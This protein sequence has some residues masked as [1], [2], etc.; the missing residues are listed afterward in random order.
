MSTIAEVRVSAEVFE[1]GRLFK[2]GTGPDAVV[3]LET[4]VPLGD[5]TVPYFRVRADRLERLLEAIREGSIVDGLRVV[6]DY[7]EENLLALDWEPD[8][9]RL[10]PDRDRL[11]EGFYELDVAVLSAHCRVGVSTFELRFE[12]DEALVLAVERG[13]YDIPRQCTTA[14]L[15]AVLGVS[16]QAVS[17]RLRRGIATLVERTFGDDAGEQP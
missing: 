15:A 11:F 9:D 4:L 8:R 12:D 17:E 6:D 3:K 10:E 1:L 7:G 5:H 13:Y 2:A 14:Q 16:D